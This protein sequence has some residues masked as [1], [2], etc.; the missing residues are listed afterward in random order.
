MAP[1][2]MASSRSLSPSFYTI[3]NPPGIATCIIFRALL[4]S[5]LELVVACE[6][7]DKFVVEVLTRK[8]VDGA[9]ARIQSL[10]FT[11]STQILDLFSPIGSYC[12][13]RTKAERSSM[14]LG[15][16]PIS[17]ELRAGHGVM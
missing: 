6:R 16:I 3:S 17:I 4:S 5:G 10:R 1:A 7:Q 9:I 8:F 15:L 2:P 13:V 11:Y 14:S 12:S